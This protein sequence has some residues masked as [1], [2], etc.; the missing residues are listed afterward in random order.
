[1]TASKFPAE[2]E[3]NLR[4]AR[5]EAKWHMRTYRREFGAHKP[6]DLVHGIR[7]AAWLFERIRI[8]GPTMA[9]WKLS[10]MRAHLLRT[11]VESEL[12]VT[13]LLGDPFQAGTGSS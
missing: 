12:I 2:C 10:A 7:K 5:I 6:V 11:L 9:E 13:D 4:R 8:E 3:A 1:M